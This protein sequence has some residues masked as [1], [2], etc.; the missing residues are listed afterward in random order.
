M[1]QD[2]KIGEDGKA[3]VGTQMPSVKLP[4]DIIPA[5]PAAAFQDGGEVFSEPEH[6]SMLPLILEKIHDPNYP[7]AE[8][9]RLIAIEIGFIAQDMAKLGKK[10]RH[11]SFSET[12]FQKSYTE[13]VKAL[14]ALEKSLTSSDLLRHRDIL[15]FDGPKF[16][17]AFGT[18]VDWFKL[19]CQQ[20]LGH[21]NDAMV[22]S[23]MKHYR[24][25]ASMNEDELRKE[26]ER[27]DSRAKQ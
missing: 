26:V 23:I 2:F 20:A 17:L 25:I 3:E 5:A 14:Q 22:Q 11:G 12:F 27:L 24:D 1:D 16:Q 8:V 13:Q 19:A 6:E 4:P 15:N 7:L 21:G 18:F 9:N 10:V